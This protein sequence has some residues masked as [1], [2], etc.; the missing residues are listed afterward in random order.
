V[1]DHLAKR[2]LAFHP[3]SFDA[4]AFYDVA[5]AF[6]ILH[7]ATPH[8]NYSGRYYVAAYFRSVSTA[9]M[10]LEAR[11]VLLGLGFFVPYRISGIFFP[12]LGF[13]SCSA[14]EHAFYTSKLN[15]P[16][17]ALLQVLP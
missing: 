4:R 8:H 5:R 1:V 16:M 14:M 12:V 9:I 11:K 17:T 15:R 13:C 3:N 6:H 2:G 10:I 7:R